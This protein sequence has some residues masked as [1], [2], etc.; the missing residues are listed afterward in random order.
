MSGERA[1]GGPGGWS[2]V[3]SERA[4]DVDATIASKLA[5][6]LRSRLGLS[7]EAKKGP[8][9]GPGLLVEGVAY[10]FLNP[11]GFC[12]CHCHAVATMG[13]MVVYFGSQLSSVFALEES[14]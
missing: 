10:F 5:S 6:H 9:R 1:A 3:G 11:S 7:A 2:D 14:A 8:T 13:S 12:E 4:S